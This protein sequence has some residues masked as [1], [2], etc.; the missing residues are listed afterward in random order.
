MG[1]F[2]AELTGDV[3]LGRWSVLNEIVQQ[4]GSDSGMIH[5]QL[6]QESGDLDAVVQEG[7]PGFT[8]LTF[9]VFLGEMV[10]AGD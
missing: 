3:C 10:G 1:N 8:S 7:V 5:S 2:V 4:A 9:V 6:R